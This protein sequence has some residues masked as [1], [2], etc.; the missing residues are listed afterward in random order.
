LSLSVPHA[1]TRV[2][3]EVEEIRIP[4]EEDMVQNG[5]KRRPMLGHH[6]VLQKARLLF[7]S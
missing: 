7:Y 2:S 5:M 3:P 6:V 4:A 1:G